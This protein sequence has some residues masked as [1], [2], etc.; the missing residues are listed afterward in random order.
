MKAIPGYPNYSISI[1]GIVYNT[2]KNKQLK[3]VLSNVGYLKVT[4]CNNGTRKDYNNAQKINYDLE[5]QK[6]VELIINSNIDFTKFGWVNQV[7]IIINKPSQKVS[8]WMNRIMPEFYENKCFKR[9]REFSLSI[10][11]FYSLIK[12]ECHYCGSSPNQEI[13][14]PK[15]KKTQI[16]YNGIDRV[17]SS[18]GYVLSNCVPCCKLCNRSK[19]D[20]QIDKWKD[21]IIRIVKFMGLK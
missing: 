18:K 9:K 14:R 12:K 19:S 4:L 15:S 1:E 21:H 10:E 6:Y 3:P 11:E 2:K 8:K 20:L 13:K 16:K 17:D 5:Q 7:A